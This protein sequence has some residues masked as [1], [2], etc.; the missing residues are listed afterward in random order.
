MAHGFLLQISV[1]L[2]VESNVGAIYVVARKLQHVIHV[3][4]FDIITGD[5]MKTYYRESDGHT[6]YKVDGAWFGAPTYVDGS[7]D[8]EN[9]GF[10]VDF[11]ITNGDLT[12]LLEWLDEQK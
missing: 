3:L 11:D 6:Y 5:T 12:Q 4:L 9:G 8:S 7:Y 1:G 10:V 2:H